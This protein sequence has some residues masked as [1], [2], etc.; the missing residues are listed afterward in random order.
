ML[1]CFYLL[2]IEPR[3]TIGILRNNLNAGIGRAE[4]SPVAYRESFFGHEQ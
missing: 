2:T 1:F 3:K 4:M